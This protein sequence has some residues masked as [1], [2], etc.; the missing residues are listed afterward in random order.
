LDYVSLLPPEIK[1][2]RIEEQRQGKILKIAAIVLVALLVVY[3]FLL[4][5]SFLTRNTLD[6]LRNER[7]DLEQQAAALQ[8]YDDLYNEMQSAEDTLN[9]AMGNVPEWDR[10]LL[11]LGL[12][13]NPETALTSLNIDYQI[14]DNEEDGNAENGNAGS[15]SFSMQGW[16]Y[17]HG[18]VSDMLERAQKLE[19]L[20]NLRLRSS[21]P[22]TINNRPA[23]EFSV[24]AVLLP[25]PLYFDPDEEGS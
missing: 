6:S 2:R 8:E 25:G 12:A 7:E 23:V 19:Q 4:V 24:D 17:S 11:D 20:E 22:A 13:M 1:Q 21:S 16:S 14:D 10:F 5:S 3:A 18:N 15:G 9:R